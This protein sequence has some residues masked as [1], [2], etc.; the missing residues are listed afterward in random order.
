[1]LVQEAQLA[2]LVGSLRMSTADMKAGLQRVAREKECSDAEVGELLEEKQAST[3][4]NQPPPQRTT[5]PSF[6]VVTCL[7]QCAVSRVA[8]EH[9][10]G[11]KQWLYC[12]SPELAAALAAREMG[13]AW[14]KRNSLS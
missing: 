12:W 3:G 14:S 1:M 2:A 8:L 11:E 9:V 5:L 4:A 10:G 13:G 6:L 7:L